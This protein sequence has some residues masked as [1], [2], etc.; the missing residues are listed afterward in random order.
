M[1]QEL[2]SQRPL[3]LPPSGLPGWAPLGSC[4][5]RQLG[6]SRCG[7]RRDRSRWLW[8]GPSSVPQGEVLSAWLGWP[9]SVSSSPLLPSSVHQCWIQVQMTGTWGF[10]TVWQMV[11]LRGPGQPSPRPTGLKVLWGGVEGPQGV[12]R[13]WPHWQQASEREVGRAGTESRLHP[14]SSGGLAPRVSSQRCSRLAAAQA[15]LLGKLGGRGYAMLLVEQG[16]LWVLPM[17]WLV[18]LLS[19]EAGAATATTGSRLPGERVC[20]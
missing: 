5:P 3:F 9:G 17:L 4:L 8:A 20:E 18:L 15:L 7:G 12:P 11:S 19:E 6:K 16:V 14:G 10:T 1:W 2:G 13:H